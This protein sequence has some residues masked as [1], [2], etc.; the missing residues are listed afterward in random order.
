M[1][2]MN[3]KYGEYLSLYFKNNPEEFKI[4]EITPDPKYWFSGGRFNV[5]YEEDLR[6]VKKIY[7]YFHKGEQ[8]VEWIALDKTIEMLK[9]K[10][11]LLNI[12]ANIKPVYLE[13]EFKKE[14]DDATTYKYKKLQYIM[15][16]EDHPFVAD[17]NPLH[18]DEIRIAITAPI[19]MFGK[20]TVDRIGG[21]N[22]LVTYNEG[23]SSI[24]CLPAEILITDPGANY[25]ID[26]E[27]IDSMQNLKVIASPSTGTNHI[28]VDYAES[29]GID[30]VSLQNNMGA[31]EDIE[32]SAEFTVALAMATIRNIPKASQGVNKG[33]WR[34][35][36]DLYRGIE[37]KDKKI[38]IIGYGRIGRKVYKII[39]NGFGTPT[40][41][42]FIWDRWMEKE[43]VY[44]LFEICDIIFCCL[45]LKDETVNF[46]DGECLKRMKKDAYFI[47]TSRGE[48][49]DEVALITTLDHDFIA[50][51]GVDVVCDE[52]NISENKLVAYAKENDNLIV[53]PHIAGLTNESQEKAF[54]IIWDILERYYL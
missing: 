53:T 2:D 50:G 26:K 20:E 25:R 3:N 39:H 37:L 36:E 4:N 29:K 54:K 22:S 31:T 38:G 5:D 24:F 47:N 45:A 42:M 6:F 16:F 12:N 48:I 49:V 19:H 30:V 15:E 46:V 23:A 17:N 40:S 21:R 27:L 13:P 14:L 1:F 41:H 43:Q 28:D 18:R 11:E 33:H 9:E 34:D 8:K 52:S 35:V 44:K 51:A 10:P 7:K 32:A